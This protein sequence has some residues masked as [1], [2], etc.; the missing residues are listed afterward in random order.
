MRSKLQTEL[1]Q[2]KPFQTLEEEAL[3]NI[4]R[5]AEV[6]SWQTSN[7]FKEMDL[8]ATQYNVLRILRGAGNDG[9]LC[10]EISER[11][12][13]KDPDI[14]RLLDRLELRGFILR[15]RDSRD[16]R[17]IT[18]KITNEGLETLNSL[19]KPVKEHNQKLLGHLS[20]EQL[21]QLISLLE[22]ARTNIS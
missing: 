8:T 16:R 14:T 15:N 19:D 3:L 22:L 10:R 4:I 13:T 2:N 7:L 20:E 9:L 21:Q 18:V 1:K 17:I 12:L 5:T 6:F 11:M